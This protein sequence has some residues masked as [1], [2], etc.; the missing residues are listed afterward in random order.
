[1]VYTHS[2]ASPQPIHSDRYRG[3][4]LQMLSP[5]I[6]V[7]LMVMGVLSG[8]PFTIVLGTGL[9]LFVWLT[10]HARYEIFH[11]RLVIRFSGPR[12]KTVLLTEIETIQVVAIPLGGQGLYVRKK[13][14]WGMVIRPSD[15][16]SFTAGMENALRE[17]AE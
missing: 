10:R 6:A 3:S 4:S 17:S 1:M 11:D 15:L 14:G 2:M 16:E 13:G 5:A 7:V 12:Q 9:A 8:D